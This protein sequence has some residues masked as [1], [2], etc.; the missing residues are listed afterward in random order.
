MQTTTHQRPKEDFIRGVFAA[1]AT[2]YDLMNTLISFNQ[3]KRWRVF[4]VGLSGMPPGGNGLDV[5][6]GTGSFCLEQAKAA[7]PNGQVTGLD[8]CEEMLAIA[9]KN[10]QNTPYQQIIKFVHGNAMDLPFADDT[11]DCA[12]IG[13]ALRNVPDITKCLQEMLRVVKP[14]GR[15]VSL[16]LAKPSIPIWKHIYYLYLNGI[17]P[18]IGRLTGRSSPYRW[19]S[20]SLKIFPHQSEILSLFKHVG[21][22]ETKCYEMTGSIVAVHVGIKPFRETMLS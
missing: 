3:H 10:I 2:R 5:C 6:C 19:L 12:T 11:F 8:F 15:V 16:E 4:A 13:F 22:P 21:M 17:M 20:D 9:Q 7:G 1:I 18:L 14:G